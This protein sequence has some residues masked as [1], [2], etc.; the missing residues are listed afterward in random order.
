M[1]QIERLTK[2]LAPILAGLA[3]LIGSLLLGLGEQGTSVQAAGC[4]QAEITEQWTDLDLAGSVLRVS[5][6]GQV[7]LPV[8]VRSLGAF[9]TVGF[10]GTKPEYGPFVAEFA[11]LSEGIYFIEPEGVGP[12]F[13][14]WLD[15]KNY[16]RV[17]F[18]PVACPVTPTPRPATPTPRPQPTRPVEVAP[19]PRPQPTQPPAP[20][21]PPPV[22]GWQGRVVEHRQDLTGRYF[23]TIAVRVVGRPAGQEVTIEAS[24][25]RATSKTG[26]KPEIAPD[27]CEFG[28]LNAGTYRLTPRD[29]GTY[30]DVTVDLTDFVLVEFYYTGP[31]PQTRWVGTVVE[32]TSGETPTEHMNSAI[33]VIVS[34]RPWHEVEIRSDGWSTTAETGHKPEYGPDACE[35][36]GLRAA[37]YTIIPKDLGASVQVT[38]DGWGWAEVRFDEVP[39]VPPPAPRGAPQPARPPQGESPAPAASPQPSPTPAGPSWQGR[40]LSNSSGERPG[41]GVSSA[42][43][44]RVRNRGRMPVTITGGGGWSATCLTGTK[45][46]YG[47]NACEFGGLWPGLYRVRPEGSDVEVEVEVDGLGLAVVEFVAP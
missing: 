29:L 45:P 47:P 12:S 34:G 37:T 43:I 46:E 32:N 4:W 15:G 36:G 1:V 38:V 30:L 40:V 13:K 41:S 3:I 33:T 19:T 6:R 44:V 7:G 9:E 35:F 10:T 8:R 16:T 11:P 39:V 26:T 5:V 21:A 25:W 22:T 24:T 2:G 14:I 28:A 18:R 42:I 31:A 20:P 17:D 23:A 27:A